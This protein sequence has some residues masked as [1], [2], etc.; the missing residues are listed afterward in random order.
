MILDKIRAVKKE[1]VAH[2]KRAMPLSELKE[3]IRDLPPPRDF[4]HA[5]SEKPCSIIAEVKRRSP[6][7]GILREDFD[8]VK[9]AFLYEENGA[10]AIS[11]LTDTEFFGGDKSFLADIKQSVRLPLLT[12]QECHLKA[13]EDV[14]LLL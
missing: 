12:A 13:L 7:K 4:R 2:L 10:A 14:P 8:H 11:V 6:S 3:V 9:I 5:V 1:E